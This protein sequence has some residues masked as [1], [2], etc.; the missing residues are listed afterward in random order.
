MQFILFFSSGLRTHEIIYHQHAARIVSELVGMLS[1]FPLERLPV[2][3]REYDHLRV[4][5]S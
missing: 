5:P 3:K 4:T 2:L 1:L